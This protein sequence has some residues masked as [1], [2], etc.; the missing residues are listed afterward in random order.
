MY[1]KITTDIWEIIIPK[2]WEEKPSNSFEYYESKN[3]E[4]GIYIGSL[5]ADEK[6]NENKLV[7]HIIDLGKGKVIEMKDCKFKILEEKYFSKNN[8]TIGILDTYDKKRKYRIFSKC[9]AKNNTIIRMN[10]HNYKCED[11]QNTVNEYFEIQDSFVFV[12]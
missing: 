12:K 3:G 7:R 10:I 8:T 11:Y 6:T 4:N 5:K 9:I 2:D 1:S